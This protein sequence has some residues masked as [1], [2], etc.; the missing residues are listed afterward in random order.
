MVRPSFN[1]LFFSHSLLFKM[2]FLFFIHEYT[3]VEAF[4]NK[5]QPFRE[6]IMALLVIEKEKKRQ[7]GDTKR[8]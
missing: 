4:I 2:K 1:Y 8:K 5:H 6:M 7:I 3:Q